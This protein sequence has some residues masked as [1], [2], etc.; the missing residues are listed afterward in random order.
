MFIRSKFEKSHINC[1]VNLNKVR[2]IRKSETSKFFYI[3][4]L[5]GRDDLNSWG[6]DTEE[7][8][9]NEYEWIF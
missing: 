5:Y 2:F 1:P 9:D 4:F 6:Y 7:Q 3:E 8:R